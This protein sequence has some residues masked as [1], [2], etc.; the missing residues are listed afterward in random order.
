MP[1]REPAPALLVLAV[2]ARATVCA[3]C[4]ARRTHLPLDVVMQALAEI[5][6]VMRIDIT[7]VRCDECDTNKPLYHLHESRD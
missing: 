7:G 6:D 4:I 5:R 1:R 2:I 3:E